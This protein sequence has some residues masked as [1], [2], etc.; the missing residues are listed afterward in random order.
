MIHSDATRFFKK[1]GFQLCLF[2]VVV[3]LLL[4]VSG[5]TLAAPIRF[6]VNW[7]DLSPDVS[8]TPDFTMNEAN[9]SEIDTHFSSDANP[10][11]DPFH[12]LGSASGGLTGF[13]SQTFTN[14]N[15]SGVNM[16]VY[17]SRNNYDGGTLEG[18]D[19]YGPTSCTGCNGENPDRRVSGEWAL[20]MTRDHIGTRTPTTVVISFSEPI[21][22][23]EFIVAS[24]SLVGSSRENAILRAFATA[25]ATGPVVKAT[26]FINISNLSDDST[27][28]HDYGDDTGPVQSNALG[29][30][31]VE[32]DGIT[33]ANSDGVFESVGSAGDDGLYHIYGVNNQNTGAYGRAKW[34]Y[35]GQPIR[36]IAVS[37]FATGT[38]S[39][40]DFSYTDQWISTIFAPFTFTVVDAGDLPDTFDTALASSGPTHGTSADLFLGSCVDSDTDGAADGEA[41]VD[42]SGGD[43]AGD[44]STP[45][46]INGSCSPTGDD[47][48]GITLL[49]PLIPGAQACIAVTATNNTGAA[50][51][52]YSFID[53]NGDGDF[54]GDTDDLLDGGD[55]AG[56]VATIPDGGVSNAIYC[57]NVPAGA[58]FNGGDTH[59]RWRL[60]AA[61]LGTDV[62]SGDTPWNGGVPDG[63]VEDYYQ[64]LTC[65]GNFVFADTGTTAGQQDAGDTGLNG[66][67]VN[68]NWGGADND[69][70]TAGDNLVFS[71]T[72]AQLG[73]VDGKYQFCGLTPGTYRVELPAAPVGSGFAT[74]VNSGTDDVDDSDGQQT[75][76]YGGP[77]LGPVFTIAAPNYGGSL[78]SLP[79][80]EDSTGDNPGTINGFPDSSDDLT[81]DFGFVDSATQDW[82][83]LPD[84]FGT[85]AVNGGAAHTVSGPYMG[86][87]VDRETSGYPTIPADGEDKSQAAPSGTTGTCSTPFDDEDGVS[88]TGNWSDG[89]GELTVISNGDAC[90]NVWL[91][92]TDG[93][94]P[95][96]DGD[97]GDTLDGVDEHVVENQAVSSGPNAIS[98]SLPADVA[99]NAAFYLRVRLT[100]EDSGGGC[101][102]AEAY[103]G[104]AASAGLATSGEVE[105]YFLSFNPTAVTL[106]QN[107][108]SERS[109]GIPW[110]MWLALFMVGAFTLA[111]LV[112]RGLQPAWVKTRD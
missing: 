31:A 36:S 56:G 77:V 97:F 3:V 52:L 71:T 37:F 49:T 105:D 100:A 55:F 58:T 90:L 53:F 75:I 17:Y 78:F 65:V 14:V 18:P 95:G 16:T 5:P 112:G 88:P 84:S 28:L 57:F 66:V 74:A 8:G 103:G 46:Q 27:L 33:D 48:D 80:S 11:K 89:S 39:F 42:G 72:T 68:L 104:T 2:F 32:L 107:S 24:M 109:A 47:D 79:T 26:E 50:A 44:S 73:G 9:P 111:V 29:N 101:G 19:M 110:M 93:S 108:V 85:S 4:L 99:N 1:R 64:P 76:G 23:E 67:T 82:G 96:S 25:D 98:F 35:T 70:D 12:G 15:N 6:S 83:D 81:F 13:A 92:Y 62:L 61:D 38:A 40:T 43:D 69:P 60:T 41:G 54:D 106:S 94:A 45:G 7:D 21:L 86:S 102:G 51:N 91:D 30:I 87:C 20:R 59:F 10:H 63:E 22:M 34:V